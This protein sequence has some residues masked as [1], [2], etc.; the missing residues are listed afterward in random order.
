MSHRINDESS[1]LTI[2][3]TALQQLIHCFQVEPQWIIFVMQTRLDGVY[4]RIGIQINKL[5]QN[6]TA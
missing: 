3:S 6:G 1:R 5:A 4:C 2:P